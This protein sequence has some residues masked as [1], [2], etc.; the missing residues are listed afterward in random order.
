MSF[1]AD[2]RGA[3]I[4]KE[5]VANGGH[6]FVEGRPGWV[7]ERGHAQPK[8]P[9]FG[10]DEM[11][12]VREKQLI[13]GKEFEVR[14]GAAQF[15]GMKFREQFEVE[16]QGARPLALSADGVP[17]AY[18]NHYKQGSAIICGSFAGQENN[19]HAVAMHPL[20]GLLTR[21]AHLCAPKLRAPAR[22]ELRQMYAP[23]KGRWTFLFNHAD[24]PASVEFVRPLERPASNIREIVT[25]QRISPAGT[26]LD[27][28]TEVPAESVR[29]YRI[30]F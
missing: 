9:G 11:F 2:R 18:E 4:L 21:W 7:D 29:I 12:G 25:G 14:W 22:L 16:D 15:K 1:D 3:K 6:L 17:I 13:P 30:D 26:N 27:L 28:K 5:Y 8:I 24:K 23:N 10:W 19:E 20:A